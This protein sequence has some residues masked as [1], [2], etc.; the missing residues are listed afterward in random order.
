MR[1]VDQAGC[2]NAR[3]RAALMNLEQGIPS[4]FRGKPVWVLNRSR[5]MSRM[6]RGRQRW[7]R[8]QGALP[9]VTHDCKAFLLAAKICTLDQALTRAVPSG[10]NPGAPASFLVSN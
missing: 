4:F 7:Q 5:A 8:S 6:G 2:E 9:A 1:T 3:V 10:S